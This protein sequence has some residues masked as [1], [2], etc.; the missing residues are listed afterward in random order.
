MP[1]V[2]CRAGSCC[3][4]PQAAVPLR[5]DEDGMSIRRMTTITCDGCGEQVTLTGD[6]QYGSEHSPHYWASLE[7]DEPPKDGE[8]YRQYK[9]LNLCPEHLEKILGFVS[10]LRMEKQDE[11]EITALPP[12]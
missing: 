11:A 6:D 9:N 10:V 1:P 7:W 5:E 8:K 4:T 3:T 12:L 2:T